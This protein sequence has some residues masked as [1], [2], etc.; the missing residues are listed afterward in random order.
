MKCPTAETASGTP[1]VNPRSKSLPALSVPPKGFSWVPAWE[2]T[3]CRSRWGTRTGSGVD[4]T[5]S[6]AGNNGKQLL[7][8]VLDLFPPTHRIA[9][10]LAAVPQPQLK[11]C[12]ARSHLSRR[13]FVS[14]SRMHARAALASSGIP[15][16]TPASA[17]RLRCVRAR[18]WRDRGAL[19]GLFRTALSHSQV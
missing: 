10:T 19:G 8:R 13:Q 4:W 2:W 15:G 11:A 18:P 6:S 1:S 12:A 14:R 3:R 5:A 17:A 7:G 9:P 16:G